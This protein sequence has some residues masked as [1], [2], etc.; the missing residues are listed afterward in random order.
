MKKEI[1]QDRKV[2]FYILIGLFIVIVLYLSV[3][4]L[5]ILN[6]AEIK[7]APNMTPPITSTMP[8]LTLTK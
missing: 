7:G 2:F 1:E 5:N 8:P 4:G 3:M 6:S